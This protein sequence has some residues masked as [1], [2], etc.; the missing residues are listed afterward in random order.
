MEYHQKHARASSQE[1]YLSRNSEERSSLKHRRSSSATRKL[2]ASSIALEAESKTIQ[3]KASTSKLA[4]SS[5]LTKMS[6]SY[7]AGSSVAVAASSSKT[8]A[9]ASSEEH[10]ASCKYHFLLLLFS[11]SMRLILVMWHSHV[12]RLILSR[13]MPTAICLLLAWAWKECRKFCVFISYPVL[14]TNRWFAP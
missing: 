3:Q 8:M 11:I 6:S 7:E 13:N 14:F 2:S 9:A 12:I 4:K 10:Y 5:S 1:R